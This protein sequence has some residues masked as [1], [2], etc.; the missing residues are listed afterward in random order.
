LAAPV[1]VRRQSTF[2]DLSSVYLIILFFALKCAP[3]TYNIMR[4]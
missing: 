2:F 1:A 3:S 4:E